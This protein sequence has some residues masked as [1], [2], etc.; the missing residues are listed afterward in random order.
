MYV[1]VYN[2]HPG[3]DLRADFLEFEGG[4]NTEMEAF[5]I[6]CRDDAVD[7]SLGSFHSNQSSRKLILIYVEGGVLYLVRWYCL[8]YISSA[9]SYPTH[10]RFRTASHHQWVDWA[11]LGWVE[12]G[13]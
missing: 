2:T 5:G 1:A 3:T 9:M 8:L 13:G 12:L 7:T 11:G 10:V 4:V 6:S